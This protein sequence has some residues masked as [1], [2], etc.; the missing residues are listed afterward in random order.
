VGQ[1]SRHGDSGILWASRAFLCRGMYVR[2]DQKQSASREQ[3]P[4]VYGARARQRAAEAPLRHGRVCG[5]AHARAAL[6]RAPAAGA[7]VHVHGQPR[8]LLRHMAVSVHSQSSTGGCS[9]RVGR[10][11]IATWRLCR[12]GSL[13]GGIDYTTVSRG[14]FWLLSPACM[15]ACQSHSLVQHPSGACMHAHS[16][17]CSKGWLPRAEY[18]R[19]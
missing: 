5:R 7:R 8:G 6:R 4:H 11:L 15:S 12:T 18:F 13:E 9:I 17:P 2:I 14:M 19:T 16:W 1:S 10:P 3:W